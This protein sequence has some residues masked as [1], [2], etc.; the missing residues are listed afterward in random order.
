MAQE[1]VGFKVQGDVSE[2]SKSI[3]SLKQQLRDAQKDVIALSEKFGATSVEAVK[4]AKKAADLRDRIGDAKSLTDAFNP[5]AKFRAFTASLSGVAGGFAA[6]QG[7]L[8]LVG[9]ESDKVEKTL[10]KV[11]SAMAISQGLQT[12]GESIDSFKQLGA[13]IRSTTLFQKAYQVATIA[14]AAVQKLFSGAVVQTGFAFK[15]LRGAI[16]TTGIGALVVGIGLLVNKIMDWVNSASEAE[17]A[18]QKLAD[19]TKMMNAEIDNQISVLS[20]LGNKEKEIYNLKLKQNDNELNVL[21][22]KL[23]KQGK[24]SEEELAQFRKLKTE[25]QVLDIQEKNRIQKDTEEETK[26]R[27]QEGKKVL[28][29]RKQRNS[30]IQEADKSLREQTEQIANEIFLSEIKN[31][32][33]REQVRIALEYEKSKNDIENSKATQAEKNKALEILKKKFDTDNKNL[34]DEFRKKDEEKEKQFQET[35]NQIKTEIRLNGITDAREKERELLDLELQK[36][37]ERITNDETLKEDAKAQLIEQL[38]IRNKQKSNELEDKFQKED[39][40]KNIE[41]LNSIIQNSDLELKQRRA[42]IEQE[43][44]LNEQLFRDKKITEEEYL[45]T[46]KQLGDAEKAIDKEVADNKKQQATEAADRLSQLADL[47]G[48]QTIAGKALG[49]AT[50]LINTYQGASEAL[51]QRSTLPSP[52]DVISKVINV[53]SIIATG[54]KTVKAIT[55][56]QIPSVGGKSGGGASPSIPS[57]SATPPPISPTQNLEAS[58]TLLNAQAIQQLGSATNRAY[59]V[60]SD[61][62]N[63]QERIR[64]INRAARL[65]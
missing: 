63:S 32:K 38:K 58:S 12:I 25:K 21:R 57:V 61:V 24:L 46:K 2:A 37:I 11:Q 40:Q 15:A 54:I 23:S 30:E 18:Q 65:S 50:A 14:A 33:E 36:D 60:E 52:F 48:K 44:E 64:R 3:G 51:K 27:Q 62:T 19:S 34:D 26:K 31:E 41:R 8:G 16:I 42:A 10:L 43:K 39:V 59:V 20:A 35:L 4:A 28:E 45:K 17:K 5:D 55:A 13:V 53:A 6:V 22:N 29:D 47:V 49:I 56:V 1:I 9:V 7:A